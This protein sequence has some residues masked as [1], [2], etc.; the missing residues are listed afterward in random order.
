MVATEASTALGPVVESNSIFVEPELSAVVG[1]R[2]TALTRAGGG[3]K[4]SMREIASAE[5]SL[6]WFVRHPELEA[7]QK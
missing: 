1:P 3:G 7:Y 5:V 2:P 6:S 4:L